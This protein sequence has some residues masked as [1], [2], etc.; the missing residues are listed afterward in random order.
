MEVHPTLFQI[1]ADSKFEF[2]LTGSKFFGGARIDSDHD[3]FV[4][5]SEEVHAFLRNLGFEEVAFPK[6]YGGETCTALYE[7][8]SIHIQVVK[9]LDQKHR[10][11][12]WLAQNANM[13]LVP[14]NARVHLWN[15]AMNACK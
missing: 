6:L 11:Q 10:A 8:G 2:Y 5:D 4:E 14:K 15:A 7:I 1:L 3:F 9:N 13:A 12:T